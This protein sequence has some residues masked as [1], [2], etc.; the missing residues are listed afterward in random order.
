MVITMPTKTTC[1]AYSELSISNS[2]GQTPV[3]DVRFGIRLIVLLILSTCASSI[4]RQTPK[5]TRKL[6][7]SIRGSDDTVL[8][9]SAN[10]TFILLTEAMIRQAP[11]SPELRRTW[12]ILYGAYTLMLLIIYWPSLTL[13]AVF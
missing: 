3:P 1:G 10:P 4:E 5:F 9:R 2:I 6:V 13:F 12:A 11:D 7:N 8:V